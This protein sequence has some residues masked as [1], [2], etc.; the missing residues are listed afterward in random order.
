[1]K[2]KLLVV[3]FFC[4]A[5]NKAQT[6]YDVNTIQK[7][8]INFSQTNWDYILDTAKAGSDSYLMATWVKINGVQFDSVGVKYKGNSSYNA[9]YNK[10]PLHIELDAFKNQ[11]Y[12]GYKDIKLGNN[13]ADPSMIREV[14]GYDILKNYMHCSKANFAKVYINGAYYGVYSNAESIGKKFYSE[15]FYSS[16]NTAFKCNPPILNPSPSTKC[17]LKYIN[18][19]SSSYFNFYE[20]KTST[21]WNELVR[22]CDTVTNFGNSIEN[23]LDIDKAIWMHSFNVALDN[24]DSYTGAFCQNFYL[25]KDNNKRFNPVIWDLN[26]CFGGLPFVGS[27]TVSLGSLS[28]SGL[29]Q[30]PINIHNTD[31]HWP[32]INQIHSNARYKKM[33]A[34]HLKTI[35]NE[36]VASN[37]Y[38]TKAGVFQALIDTSV[39]SDPYKFYTYTQFQNGLTA[40]VSVGSY[41]VPGIS[42]LLGL[43]NTYLQAQPEFTLAQPT[44]TNIAFSPALPSISDTIWVTAYISNQNYSYLG[45]RDVTSARFTKMQMYDDGLHH[46]GASGDG[47]F[48]QKLIATSPTLEY[49]IY[50]ENSNAGIFSPQRAEYEFHTISVAV[51]TVNKN[52]IFLNELMAKNNTTA[53]DNNGQYD[54]WLEIYNNTSSNI[55]LGSVYLSDNVSSL[56]KWRFPSNT[57][58]PAHHII[59]VWMDQ[60][61]TQTGYHANFKLSASGGSVFLSNNSN[62]ILDSL[63]FGAQSADVSLR[64]CPDGTGNWGYTFAPSFNALNCNVGVSENK[65]SHSNLQ[66]SP[67]PAN[68]KLAILNST[69][70]KEL[71]IYSID[72]KL[73]MQQNN[74][75][76]RSISIVT[77]QFENGIY[78]IRINQ[79]ES[80]KFIVQH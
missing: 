19:D 7:I 12:Q 28:I 27:G 33:Y 17:N 75:Q 47:T 52:D 13:Y 3:S 66:I 34:A 21:G 16:S 8:E 2:L 57:V 37:Y 4:I 41:S 36:M 29:Q 70:I 69:D 76:N 35:I 72:G 55:N 71:E 23:N 30:L 43:R 58:I 51:P 14:L 79:K 20:L 11:S 32:L 68:E 64:R 80:K 40:N 77:S 60:D 9:T 46:D 73:I 65:L 59:E 53:A 31:V 22:L 39:Q 50:S 56:H 18:N 38:Q 44:I 63:S 61:T 67:I 48:G 42:T 45:Y 25:Y 10:N 78:L 74:I 5:F 1:M 24:L 49:Y 26:M 6:F 15:H 62:V 54:D